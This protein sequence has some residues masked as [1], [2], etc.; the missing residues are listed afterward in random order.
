MLRNK[1]KIKNSLEDEKK[2]LIT[3]KGNILKSINKKQNTLSLLYEDRVNGI[4]DINEFAILK[5]KNNNDAQNLKLR[6]LKIEKQ[7]K[8]L[9]RKSNEKKDTEN[10]L[11]KYNKINKL[12]RNILDEFISRIDVG[13]YDEENK[14]RKI[15]IQWNITAT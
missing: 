13:L 7:I 15:T 9:E 11:K 12:T 6:L 14:I 1:Q 8:E 5:N 3:E 4:I 10:I 2:C